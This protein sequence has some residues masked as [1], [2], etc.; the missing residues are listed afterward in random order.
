M[1]AVF[2]HLI[3]EIKSI[4]WKRKR[5]R[6]MLVLKSNEKH[7]LYVIIIIPQFSWVEFALYKGRIRVIFAFVHGDTQYCYERGKVTKRFIM[8]QS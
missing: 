2:G 5:K 4:R 3:D 7:R 6:T 1:V 8:I